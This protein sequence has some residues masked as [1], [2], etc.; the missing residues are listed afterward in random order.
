MKTI[1]FLGKKIGDGQP[2][3]IIAEIGLNHN[4]ST[5]LAKKLIDVAVEAGCDAVKFQKRDVPSLATAEFLD[6]PDLRFPEF[7]K[8]YREV[9]EHV[10]FSEMQLRDLKEYAKGKN[11]PFFVT[12]FDIPSAQMIATVGVDAYKSASHNLTHHPLLEH[13][14]KTKKPIIVSTGMATL[15]EVDMA[16]KLLKKYK[17]PFVLLHCVSSY[18]TSANL[19]NLKTMDLL[20]QRYGVPVGYSGHEDMS[21]EHLPTLSAVA[22]GACVVERHITLDNAMMGFDHKISANPDDL[23]RLVRQIRLIETML[24]TGKKELLKEELVKRLQQRV[25]IVSAVNI[26][27]GDKI[28]K[29]MLAFKAPGTGMPTYDLDKVIGKKAKIDIKADTLIT[30]KFLRT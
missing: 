15:K 11:I 29:A 30:K 1:K 26:K 22:R 16:V 3:F 7:G 9:R 14:A 10:E 25:S 21:T 24:G 17:V 6:Q 12:P 2:V 28:T 20:R 8:T 23:K 19:I 27:K 4:G 5:Q 18:P 13:L